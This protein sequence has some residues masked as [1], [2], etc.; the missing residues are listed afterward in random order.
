MLKFS[1]EFDL[2]VCLAVWLQ[3]SNGMIQMH[4]DPVLTR[5]A[6]V[7]SHNEYDMNAL[8]STMLY[9]L[10]NSQYI[11]HLI[12]DRESEHRF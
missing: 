5:R 10:P 8:Y 4:L 12:P 6:S 2:S 9:Y 3:V 1:N 7:F 11:I